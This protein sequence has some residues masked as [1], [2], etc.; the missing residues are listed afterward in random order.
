MSGVELCHNADWTKSRILSQS[1]WNDGEGIGVGPQAV[2]VGSW[3]ILGAGREFQGDVCFPS[4][5]ACQQEGASDQTADAAQSVMHGAGRL[6]QHET[7]GAT[8]DDRDGASWVLDAGDLK[9]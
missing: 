5:P 2:M 9:F 6:G 7:V 4:A 3:G 1:G 8:D